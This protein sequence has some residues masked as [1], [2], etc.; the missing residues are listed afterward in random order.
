M[1]GN[2]LG[3]FLDEN[4]YFLVSDECVVV[5]ILVQINLW[6]GLMEDIEMVSGG[7]IFKHILDYEGIPF[8]YWQCHKKG[9]IM[10]QFPLILKPGRKDVGCESNRGGREAM[11]AR[12]SKN[13][14]DDQFQEVRGR[15]CKRIKAGH[16]HL[17]VLFLQRLSRWS[18]PILKIHLFHSQ[19]VF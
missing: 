19:E 1:I 17:I 11:D 9:N 2:S 10:S 18:Q 13:F 7:K 3:T 16:H 5:C 4:M 12:T 6:E 14:V 15:A 8:R